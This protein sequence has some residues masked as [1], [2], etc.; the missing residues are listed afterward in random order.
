MALG[1]ARGNSL[2][3]LKG[4]GGAGPKVIMG[5]PPAHRS[6]DITENIIL[7]SPAP[8]HQG[9]P[10]LPSPLLCLEKL[11]LTEK[12]ELGFLGSFGARREES[13]KA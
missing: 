2:P 1:P 12:T 7:H 5:M 9:T 4:K 11:R 13:R 6:L 10:L 3:R 8:S